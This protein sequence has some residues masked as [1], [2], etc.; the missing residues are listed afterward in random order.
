MGWLRIV[1]LLALLALMVAQGM[2]IE[3]GSLRPSLRKVDRLTRAFL[4]VAVAVP[5]VSWA[6]IAV[7][8]PSRPVVGAI[9]LMAA[10]PLAPFS[11][12]GLLKDP[13]G[14][15]LAAFH[16]LIAAAT[17]VI[18]PA[19]IEIA[20]RLL[21]VPMRIGFWPVARL[22]LITQLLPVAAGVA[23]RG[24]W[25]RAAVKASRML[26]AIAGA[27]FLAVALLIVIVGI[28]PL[29]AL[30]WRA[31]IAIVLTGLL[32]LAAG[33]LLAWDRGSARTLLATDAAIRN[34]ALALLLARTLFPGV[35]AA[36][37]ILPYLIL[38]ALLSAGYRAARQKRSARRQGPMVGRRAEA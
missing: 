16:L 11:F 19:V 15:D 23:V 37:I 5:L 7:V 2:L 8:Q 26:T 25:P 36:P 18:T 33:H 35:P 10:S 38:L 4:A 28:R 31:V 13:S 27:I 34:P 22:A 30:G 29:L 21:S 14:R 6:V 12:P 3:P 1:L 9:V 32:S 20:G 17:V 24:R